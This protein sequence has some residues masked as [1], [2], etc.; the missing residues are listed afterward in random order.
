MEGKSVLL[1]GENL[2]A[3][4]AHTVSVLETGAL[5]DGLQQKS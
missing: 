3:R 1:P 5:N 2:L 4:R